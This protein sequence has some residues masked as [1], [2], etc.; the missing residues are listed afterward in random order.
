MIFE[1]AFVEVTVNDLRFYNIRD[2]SESE[3]ADLCDLDPFLLGRILIQLA[4]C[5]S[6]RRFSPH[7]TG[8]F[9]E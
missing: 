8:R 4:D 1:L 3:H 7:L 6:V 5:L 9:I 2:H